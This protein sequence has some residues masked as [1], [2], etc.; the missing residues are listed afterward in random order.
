M[1]GRDRV[2]AGASAYGACMSQLEVAVRRAGP[3]EIGILERLWLMFRHDLSEFRGVLPGPDGSFRSDRLRA[4]VEDP[5]WAAYLVWADDRP[6]GLALVRALDQP[7]RVL[8]GFF[9]VRGARRTGTGS[10]AVLQV[11]ANHPG[12]WEVAFQADNAAAVQF[13]RRVASATSGDAWTEERRAVPGR[14]DLPPDV[15]ISFSHHQTA[16][17]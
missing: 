1:A 9:V 11:L 7:V 6:V 8:N 2:V 4:A 17:P 13:W 14:P 10:R 5:A 3:H 12:P 16:A 15:W